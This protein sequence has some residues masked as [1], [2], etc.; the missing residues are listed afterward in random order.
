MGAF[1]CGCI[2]AF[3]LAKLEFRRA[4]FAC[5]FHLDFIGAETIVSYA[6][7]GLETSGDIETPTGGVAAWKHSVKFVMA[8]RVPG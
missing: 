3:A 1:S 5:N 4:T 2:S 7:H 6:F 8:S